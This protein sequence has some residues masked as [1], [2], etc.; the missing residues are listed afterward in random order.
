ML[1][2]GVNGHTLNAHLGCRHPGCRH[3]LAFG[4]ISEY[5]PIGVRMS[6]TTMI[7]TAVVF[8]IL[9]VVGYVMIR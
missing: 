2:A 5:H 7:F 1:R 9:A 8:A 4:A 3:T 6:K